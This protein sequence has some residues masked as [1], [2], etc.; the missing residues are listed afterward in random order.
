[1]RVTTTDRLTAE[2]RDAI[3]TGALR[4]GD[5]LPSTRDL[6]RQ[7]GIARITA[8]QVYERLTAE[9]FLDVTRGRGTFV[10]PLRV[11]D[12]RRSESPLP[13]RLSEWCRRLP[14]PPQQ[15]PALDI[16]FQPGLPAQHLFPTTAWRRALVRAGA[17]V[18]HDLWQAEHLQGYPPLREALA[19]FLRQTRGVLADAEDIVIVNG[20]QQALDLIARVI[21][22]AGD[23]VVVEDPCYPGALSAFQ[24]HGAVIEPVPVD[25]MG[26]PTD[27]LPPDGV[28][29]L[30]FT[31]AHQF[32]MGPVLP[33]QRRLALKDW[34][35]AH[36]ALAIED[37]YDSELHYGPEPGP[38]FQSLVPQQV[39]YLGTFS[40]T[41]FPGL[42]LAY[43]IVPRSLRDAV[44]RTKAVLDRQS[45]LL[46][47]AIVA[48]FMQQGHWLR[49][50]TRLRRAYADQGRALEQ[51]LRA[52]VAF[53]HLERSPSSGFHVVFWLARHRAADVAA[54]AASRGLGVYPLEPYVIRKPR[55][56][57]LLLGFANL[58]PE[59]IQRGVAVLQQVL[60][61]LDARSLGRS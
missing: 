2:L 53:G 52:L 36:G 27:Q 54:A 50:L 61:D 24:A 46:L 57:A 49:H 12:P 20:S 8:L 55:A 42:R 15:R 33:L 48:E 34:L 18:G 38:A 39:L 35:L 31:P 47:Q 9:G 16:D 13:Y 26:L 51:H 37:D 56:E 10:A 25:G 23:R 44:L 3:L 43:M 30:F 14:A 1:M 60:E 7:R 29:L 58:L 21:L 41:L 59:T 17:E 4:A 40:K 32:P 22:D 5:R 6:A 28:R 45:P 11:Q 19:S